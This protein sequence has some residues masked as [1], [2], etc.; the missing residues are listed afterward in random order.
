MK[1]RAE[2][3]GLR[4]LAVVPVIF[5]HAGFEI[6]SGGF[7]GVDVFFVISGYLITTIITTELD[8]G[9]FS[10]VDFY[11]RRAR[12]I[13]PA[14]FFVMICSLPFA[15][16]LL[17]PRD[18]VDF[19]QSL[20]AVSTFSSNF[21]FWQESGYFDTSSELKPLLHTWSL[22][23][24]EQYYILFPLFL[25]IAWRLRKRWI[26]GLLII[27]FAISFLA[28]QWGSY[29]KPS[30]AFYLLPTRGWELLLGSFS[31]L[32]LSHRNLPL[33][34]PQKNLGSILGIC[35]IAYAIFAYEKHTPFPGAYALV[36][37]VGTTLVILCTTRATLVG[38]ILGSRVF[39]GIGLISYSAYLWHQPLFAF[40]R[41]G[42]LAEL[43]NIEMF[44][45]SF[46]TFP[47]AY[48]SWRYVEQPF[49]TTNASRPMIFSA[50][51][52]F[53]SAF[54][55][56]GILGIWSNGFNE[57]LDPYQQAILKFETYPRQSYY[58]EQQ[59]FLRENQ[60]ASAFDTVCRIEN[61]PLLWGD[62]HAAALFHGLNA[63]SGISQY[64]SG[65]CP[66]LIGMTSASHPDCANINQFVLDFVAREKPRDIFLHATWSNYE[67]DHIKSSLTETLHRIASASP[68][69]R[70]FVI[71]GVPHWGTLGLPNMIARLRNTI[72]TAFLPTLGE[73]LA[74]DQ[75]SVREVDALIRETIAELDTNA[76]F[77]S[78][79]S[80]LCEDD[81]CV[82]IVPEDEGVAPLAWDYGHLT[83]GGS[84]M[85][86]DIILD[87]IQIEERLG[88][89]E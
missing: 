27:I 13:L 11:E 44:A 65:A 23:V 66:P 75:T 86:A 50:S 87:N 20:I 43:T 58:R 72:G 16:A 89:K 7:I 68:T 82:A 88:S 34:L 83:K 79:L 26:V 69:S 14:L 55:C 73:R 19:S 77:I 2:I 51:I 62:S 47:L 56:I 36:P 59:C 1:Y 45:L 81:F 57:R 85:A 30:A 38:K 54:S 76:Q 40:S 9:E 5:F 29:N 4:A 21:L 42:S 22:A 31:A 67:K 53:L 3:D 28:A 84:T 48:L 8:R 52:G 46:L 78:I 32:F 64:T 24:E 41:Y 61:A 18:L 25:M 70:V 49:R 35:F 17:M 39:V 74:A 10:L 71:G 60:T 15:W 6:F 37:T 80:T 33:S 12:R 63:E